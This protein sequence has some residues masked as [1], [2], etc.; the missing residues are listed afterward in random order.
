MSGWNPPRW[1]GQLAYGYDPQDAPDPLEEDNYV[2]D[3]GTL[4]CLACDDGDHHTCYGGQCECEC[5]GEEV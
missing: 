1:V 2:D 5:E 4:L 3:N